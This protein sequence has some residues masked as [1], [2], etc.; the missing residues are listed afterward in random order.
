MELDVCM[1]NSLVWP[2]ALVLQRQCWQPTCNTQPL[3]RE[4]YI[5]IDS[6]RTIINPG[7]FT[8]LLISTWYSASKQELTLVAPSQAEAV[9]VSAGHTLSWLSHHSI[10]TTARGVPGWAQGAC[11]RLQNTREIHSFCPWAELLYPCFSDYQKRIYTLY[12]KLRSVFKHK[13]TG[14]SS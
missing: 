9:S 3:Q 11:T 10:Y 12:S 1:R 2:F 6:L 8:W 13:L 5:Y 4:K 14:L 7:V